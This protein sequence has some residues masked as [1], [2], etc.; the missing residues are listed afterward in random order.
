MKGTV[1]VIETRNDLEVLIKED[2]AAAK[3][4][5][6]AMIDN[7]YFWDFDGETD[8]E[9][10]ESE[11]YKITESEKEG[12]TIRVKWKKSVNQNSLLFQIGLNEQSAAT[13]IQDIA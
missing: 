10:A 9:P 7:I 6:Q 13:L 5:I 2:K 11:T 3:A 4:T 8:E 1:K 12:E